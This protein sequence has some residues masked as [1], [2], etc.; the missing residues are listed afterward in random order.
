MTGSERRIQAAVY[1]HIGGS[2]GNNEDN[3]YLDGI[4][5]TLD[6]QNQNQLL[7]DTR[8]Q[9]ALF[10]VCDGMGGQ[11]YGEM[12]SLV[13][14]SWIHES[15]DVLLRGLDPDKN[16]CM[17]LSRL[18]RQLWQFCQERKYRMGSTVVMAAL[19]DDGLY[20]Y[21]L[22]DSRI[23]LLDEDELQQL[24]RDHT[25]A[26]EAEF[27]G[28]TGGRTLSASDP[29]S[30]QLTQYFGMDCGEYDPTPSCVYRKLQPGQ[31]ILLCSDGL[32]DVLSE[33]Q[34]ALELARETPLKSVQGLVHCA[35]EQGGND[36]ITAMVLAI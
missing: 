26:A 32:S 30:H 29:R 10:L 15:R 3:Y 8:K 9:P 4:W 11:Q 31:R 33:A 6:N 1:C 7:H 13:A 35:L 19:R 36:N 24:T 17:I 23:Y 16:G 20:A 22:G 28:L 18:S 34:I 14:V 21:G 27:M 25:A 12:A 2:R 5:K